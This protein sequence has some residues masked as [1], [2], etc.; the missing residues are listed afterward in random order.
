MKH[1]DVFLQVL[2][3]F[4]CE[5]GCIGV[6]L[7][8]Y[9]LMEKL[10]RAVL[11]GA[12]LGGLVAIGNFLTLSITVSKAA[13]KAEAGGEG[14]AAKATVAVQR[15]SI[16]RKIALIIIYV[17]LLKSGYCDL[18]ATILPLIFVQGSIYMTEFFRKDGAKKT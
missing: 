5:V 1:K 15:S 7:L 13:D 11:L 9:S 6:M 18:L 2:R 10:D 17:L 12:L 3:I 14:A 4:L 8:I 16:L